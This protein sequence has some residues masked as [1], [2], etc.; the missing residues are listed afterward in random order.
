[1]IQIEVGEKL[2]NV[3]NARSWFCVFN[4]PEN[5]GFSGSPEEI[6][7]QMKERWIA[8]NPQRTCAVAYCISAEGLHHC[9]AVFEDTK[10]MRFTVVQKLFPGMHIE[11]TKGNKEQ[12]EDYI[13][14]RG[15][16]KEKDESVLCIVRHGEIKGKQGARRDFEIIEDLIR[17]GKTPNEIMEV[18]FSFRRYEK[19]IRDEYYCNRLAY[20]PLLR[21][22]SVYWHVGFSGSGKSYTFV[23]LSEQYGENHVYF[24]NDYDHGFDKYNGEPILFM[25][26]FRG[27]MKFSLFLNLLDRYKVQVP[28]RYSNVYSLWNEV[29]I[30]SVLPPERVYENMVQC[31]RNLDTV[32]QLTRRI[33]FIVYHWKDE[34]GKF[35]EFQLPMKQYS[36]YDSL[37]SLA[38][39][40]SVD[41]LSEFDI[42]S[43]DK[44][45]SESHEEQL[46]FT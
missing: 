21:D 11:A 39:D 44:P 5:H 42:F 20:T 6:A 3:V 14:K 22:V 32:E 37:Q 41:S 23:K 36:D 43:D 33:S 18:S 24:L 40:S 1:M 31:N 38:E 9:H 26:E 16:W 45:I 25:D 7:E 35:R 2:D 8:D 4:N 27:Q 15:K 30:T 29:H 19:M 17:E 46:H 13:N 28:C 10:T 12:A 34:D